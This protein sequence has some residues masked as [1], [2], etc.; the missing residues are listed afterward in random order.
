MLVTEIAG[1]T[2]DAIDSELYLNETRYIFIDTSGI[3][4]KSK[5]TDPIERHSVVRAFKSL[6][7]CHIAF[8]LLDAEEG[9]TDQDARIAG[10]AFENGRAIIPW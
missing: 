3:R 9:V 6:D 4:R 10:Y 2:R 1:T 7:R 8:V 5:I